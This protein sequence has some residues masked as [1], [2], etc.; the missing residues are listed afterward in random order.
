MLL[1]R[2]FEVYSSKCYEHI[3][4]NQEAADS[5]WSHEHESLKD[6]ETEK[7]IVQLQAQIQRLERENTDFLAALEDAME[8]Y[9]QQVRFR[10]P[11][12]L[13]RPVAAGRLSFN[14]TL[15]QHQACRFPFLKK[16]HFQHFH[17][18]QSDKLQE[19]QDL[20]AELQCHLSTPG[21]LG[22]GLNLS[23]RPHT[24]PMGS[25]QHGPNGGIYRQ[26]NNV[27]YV[28]STYL[29]NMSPGNNWSKLKN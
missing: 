27:F 25:M 23:S 6:G 14:F 21:L 2:G 24:A 7:T 4:Q 3:T 18:S 22:L 16:H 15:Y 8:Q 26:V 1:A 10:T 20:I 13:T 11:W 19:Q 9:K 29:F 28:M 12:G 5:S 17:L